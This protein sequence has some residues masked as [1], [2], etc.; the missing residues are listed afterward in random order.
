MTSPALRPWDWIR[1]GL[2]TVV[3]ILQLLDALPLPELK[4]HHL[5]NPVAK[6]EL[7]RWSEVITGLGHAITPDE[8][9]VVGLELGGAAGSF[10]K[11]VLKPWHPFRRWTGTGQSWGLFAYPE[12]ASGR[13]VV[14]GRGASGVR[15]LYRAPGGEGDH[16]ADI[17]EYRRIRGVYDDAS[18]RPRPRPIYRRFGE[19]VAVEVFE[20]HPDIDYVE[21]RLDLHPIITPSEGEPQP[22][23]RRHVRG[24]NRGELEEMGLLEASP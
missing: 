9:A 2:I 17:L 15:T 20:T 19:W 16:L 10:R 5:N 23:Q 18:D 8:L 6:R 3:I 24:F 1:A 22:D 13:L 7:V 21:I 4:R 14:D 11:L 12:P